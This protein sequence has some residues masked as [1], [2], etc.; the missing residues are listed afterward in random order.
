M[1][2]LDVFKGLSAEELA[3]F[4]CVYVGCEGCPC[5]RYDKWFYGVYCPAT[6]GNEIRMLTNWL[7]EE[8]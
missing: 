8:I 7:K 2:R 1:T 5:A 4:I 6:K 3:K